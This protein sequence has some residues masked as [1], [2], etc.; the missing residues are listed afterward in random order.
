[1][2]RQLTMSTPVPA[3][4]APPSPV[5]KVRYI[6]PDLARGLALLGIALANLPTAWAVAQ[7]ADSAGFFGGIYGAATLPE[8]IVV[9]LQ[10]MFVHVRGLPMFTTLLGFGVGLITMSL[11]R[12]G[13]PPNK[14]RRVLF[15]RYGILA[16][17]GV[18]HLVL[19]FF[20]DIIVQYSLI[21]FVLIAMITLRDRTLMII[22]WVLLGLNVAFYT[23][24]GGILAAFPEYTEFA[25]TTGVFVEGST[26]YP[27]YLAFNA[28]GLLATL[29]SSPITGL[30]LGPL[31]IIG[32]VWARRG[33]LVDVTAHLRLLW[34]WV[35][36]AATVIVLIGLPWGLAAIGVLPP[37]WELPLTI[38]NTG[39]GLFTGPGILA[40]VAL[41]FRGTVDT[42]GPGLR[43]FVALGQR[44]MS[45]YILQSF[46][47]LVLTQPFTL[48]WGRESGILAQTGIALGVWTT[49]LVW[50]YLWDLRGWPGPVEWVH[51]R[52]SYGR[53]GLPPVY[54]AAGA[55]PAGA[56]IPGHTADGR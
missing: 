40:L 51:R 46:L 54:R 26:S 30:M 49:T 5:Q 1:M 22:A 15:R 45:G 47:F 42:L 52:L 11:W 4:S 25:A 53:H 50:A 38:I 28:L 3:P 20:G 43:A 56:E 2:G 41:L 23:V 44:S 18:V 27:D 36:V 32:F 33:V 9:V 31:M 35:A 13:F 39:A 8:Q 34:S 10:A 6:A 48:G 19:L 17:I 29:A 16:L 14:A 7:N 12:R 55:A 24:V 37:E 21:A